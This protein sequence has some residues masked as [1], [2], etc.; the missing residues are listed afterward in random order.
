VE[1]TENFFTQIYIYKIVYKWNSQ[2]A[3]SS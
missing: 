3:K 1:I 2:L